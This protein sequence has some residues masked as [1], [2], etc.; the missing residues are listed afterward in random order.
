LAIYLQHVMVHPVPALWRVHRLHHAD[1]D[2]DMTTGVRVHPIEIILSVLIKAG[3]IAAI[4]ATAAGVL[5]FEVLL[6]AVSMFNHGNVSDNHDLTDGE[7]LGERRS[8][9]LECGLPRG[10]RSARRDGEL[11]PRGLSGRAGVSSLIRACHQEIVRR[12]DKPRSPFPVNRDR[13]I[14]LPPGPGC[15][16]CGRRQQKRPWPHRKSRLR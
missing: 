8:N 10:L 13:S 5:I 11:E 16:S 14:R 4:G 15:R 1:L 6:N 12:S 3:V 7:A 2:F 9:A